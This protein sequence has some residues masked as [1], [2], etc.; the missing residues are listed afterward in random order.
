MSK[1]IFNQTEKEPVFRMKRLNY[2]LYGALALSVSNATADDSGELEAVDVIASTPEDIE[3]KK[4]GETVKTAETLEKQQVQDTRDLVKYETG[5]TVVEK[6][7]MGSSGY[8]IRGVDENRVNIT[9]DGLGQAETLSSSGFQELFEG[10][11]NFNNTRNGVEVENMKEVNIGKGADSTK[12][13]SG[14]LGGAVVFETKD[15]RD[16]LIDKDWYYKI[17]GGY[18]SANEQSMLSHTLAGRYKDFDAL[19]VRTDREGMNLKNFGYDDYPD[20][21]QGRSRQKADPY[22]ISKHSTLVKLG[23]NPSETNRFTL[24]L[25]DGKTTSKGTDWSYTLKQ[26]GRTDF[27]K[28][29]PE[30]AIRH[31]NDSSTRQNIAFA[32]E[33][34]DENPLWDSAKLTISKQK[35]SQRARTDEYCEGG[36]KCDAYENP[37]G[38]ELKENNGVT[39]IVDKYGKRPELVKGVVGYDL[40]DSKGKTYVPYTYYDK[41][42]DIWFD[43]SE[44]DCNKPLEI[45][46]PNWTDNLQDAWKTVNLN[47]KYKENGKQFATTAEDGILLRPNSKGW[48][49]T[50]WKDR[51]LNTDT[52]QVDLDFS[53]TFDIKG[54]EH[55]L[56]YGFSYAHT[57][58]SMINYAGSFDPLPGSKAAWWVSQST[59]GEKCTSFGT[60]TCPYPKE[61]ASSFLVPV[62]VKSGALY[63]ADNV[64]VN[65]W[66]SF[67]AD[68]RYDRVSYKPTYEE[69][70]TPR[71]PDG[72]VAVIPPPERPNIPN[73]PVYWD[74]QK[75]PGNKVNWTTWEWENNDPNYIK[76]LAEYNSKYGKTLSD[77]KA[78]VARNPEEN[79]KFLGEQR[80]HFN[81]HSYSFGTTIDPTDYLRVQAKFSKGFRAPTADEIY[82]T[83]KHPSFT[84]YPNFDLKP[85]TAKTKELA[86]TLHKDRSYLT[87][88]AFR[89]DYK[90]F[91]ELH[92]EGKKSYPVGPNG[93]SLE[94]DTYKNINQQKAKVTGF[95]VD[96]KLFL[97]DIKPKLEGFSVGYKYTHQKGKIKDKD[98]YHPMNAIQPDKHV[99]NL[100]YISPEENY[101]LDLYWTHVSAKKAND[102]Y[103]QF[104]NPATDKDS[105]AKYRSG[106]YNIFDLI[107]FYK[108][109]KG[110]TI[111]AGIYNILNKDY[112]T[113]DNARSIRS[114]GTSNMV[115]NKV[116]DNADELGCGYV[117]QGIERFHSPE[118]NAKISFEYKF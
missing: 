101:G 12:V 104:Y 45:L 74:T 48:L 78:A 88:S 87:L 59:G 75:Y 52:K 73:P 72:I 95:E 96:S 39:Q 21:A 105:F 20:N 61:G 69:G 117:G 62:K 13:G 23:Y 100:G 24:M 31:A 10:Y 107:G 71:I 32:Y 57:E 66:L 114:F 108:P 84:L 93:G 99:L 37:A 25:D 14:A 47:K 41:V 46:K 67:N 81:N 19:V 76:D 16:Y 113:W 34:Y 112:M 64:R 36:T 28:D 29:A 58:K 94:H 116:Y 60:F 79:A 56:D 30:E 8:A 90:D 15:A 54:T 43:C 110:M 26:R 55:N 86:F 68:Y 70:K 9:V 2:L 85:E 53:K 1:K 7:R 4:I 49:Q 22:D 11:G 92:Y 3:N 106:S 40:K 102:T 17:K 63:F 91:I 6:G 89:T 115:C 82:F 118:R 83:F 44:I 38:L 77:W 50:D 5:V 103:N 18:S 33:N 111:R 97:G 27:I 65:D 51:S 98:G 42:K 35:I 109:I 80:R